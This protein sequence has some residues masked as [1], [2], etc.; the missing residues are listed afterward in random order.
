MSVFAQRL[1]LREALCL[2]QILS[3]KH[4]EAG[5]QA[6]IYFSGKSLILSVTARRL[7]QL[8]GAV[9]CPQL[10][11]VPRKRSLFGM[12]LHLSLLS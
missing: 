11:P 5:N 12:S 3:V 8:L 6:Y 10:H 9:L 2:V 1:V 7:S 4:Q